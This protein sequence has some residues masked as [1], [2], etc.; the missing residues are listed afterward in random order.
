MS[1]RG[2]AV[3]LK[4]RAR[5]VEIVNWIILGMNKINKLKIKQWRRKAAI[6]LNATNLDLYDVNVIDNLVQPASLVEILDVLDKH[7]DEK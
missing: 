5:E 1:K 7:Y 3:G 2:E 6:F 4:L